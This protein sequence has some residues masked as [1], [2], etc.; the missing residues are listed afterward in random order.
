[1]KNIVKLEDKS[2]RLRPKIAPNLECIFIA[3][4]RIWVLLLTLASW[5]PIYRGGVQKISMVHRKREK[6]I[7]NP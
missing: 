5:T 4:R 6:M 1:M 3:G 7:W 2:I